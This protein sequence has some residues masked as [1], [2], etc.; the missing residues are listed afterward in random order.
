MRTSF[1]FLIL[2]LVFV[3]S[4]NDFNKAGSFRKNNNDVTSHYQEGE[5]GY[6]LTFLQEKLKPVEL[7]NGESRLVLVPEYQ[8]RVMTSSSSGMKGYSHGW[9]NYGLIASLEIDEH[10]NPYGGEERIWLG[11]EGGPFSVFFTEGKPSYHKQW[12]V[13]AALDHEAFDI[14]SQNLKSVT[15]SKDIRLKN[16][17]GTNFKAKITRTITILNSSEIGTILGLE[18]EKSINAVAYQSENQ[19]ENSGDNCWD[20]ENGALSIWMLSMLKASLDVTVVFP[21]KNAGQADVKD[22][23]GSI[24]E[25]R[26]RVAEK[27]VFFRVDGKFRSKIGIP[28]Y[29][30]CPYIGSYDAKNKILSIIE[31]SLPENAVDYVNSS[32][33]EKDDP[34][35][36]DVVN[37]Y[38]DG[39]LGNGSQIGQLYELES[40]S[41][42]AFLK[43]GESITHIQRIYH[44]EG[45][46]KDLNLLAISLLKVSIEEIKNTF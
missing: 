34:F 29:Q 15:L 16:Y 46:E 20:K 21:L 17:S 7:V 38:N 5:Y 30:A 31:Y 37:S 36:G 28:P 26:L 44:F 14:E 18:Y 42:A 43:P 41:P 23:F 39:P 3:L 19:L 25:N 40:S 4:C 45:N 9:I 24:P 10:A 1:I 33:E 13:P 22:Y 2:P 32:F 27:A 12:T 35:S 6:D 8:G 11:P